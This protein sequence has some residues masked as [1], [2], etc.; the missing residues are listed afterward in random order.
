MVNNYVHD[1]DRDGG[2]DTVNGDFCDNN[3]DEFDKDG[4]NDNNAIDDDND[5]DGEDSR[6]N[7]YSFPKSNVG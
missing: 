4:K 1:V 5:D 7:D 3:A 2:N 6:S